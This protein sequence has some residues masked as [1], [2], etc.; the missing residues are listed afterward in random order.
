MSELQ[1]SSAATTLAAGARDV[2]NG[3]GRSKGQGEAHQWAWGVG[4]S[5]WTTRRWDAKERKTEEVGCRLFL[6]A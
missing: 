3:K 5:M 1:Y 6:S 4:P 2:G